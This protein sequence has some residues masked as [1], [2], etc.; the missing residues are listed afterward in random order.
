MPDILDFVRYPYDRGR[1]MNAEQTLRS[2]ADA[3]NRAALDDL[4]AHYADV[5]EYHQPFL[6][7]PLTSPHTIHEFESSMFAAFSD[8]HVEIEWMVSDGKLASAGMLI[9]AVHTAEMPTP[10]GVL[11]AT[12]NPIAIASAEF[13]EID[14]AGRIICHRRYQD[15]GQLMAQL[16]L[17]TSA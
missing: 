11:A 16:H 9:R 14:D 4:V 5:T 8:V 10:T 2:Y 15:T 7:T 6:P 17:Q 13:I 12:G 1:N 3:F